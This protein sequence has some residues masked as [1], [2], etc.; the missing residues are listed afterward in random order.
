MHAKQFGFRKGKSTE[1]ALCMAVDTIEKGINRGQYVLGVFCD[2]SG[3][4]DNVNFSSITA[5]M[6]NRGVAPG[7]VAWYEHFLRNRMV[8]S[9]IGGSKAKVRPG[10]GAPQGGVLSAIIAWNLV[11][12][13]LLGSMTTPRS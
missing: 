6:L 9:S 8:T 13:D 11:F 7:I 10:K 3:A 1:H 4:F 12:D 2:I 5:A